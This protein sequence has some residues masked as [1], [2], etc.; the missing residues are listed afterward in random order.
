MSLIAVFFF[1]IDN[2]KVLNL[3]INLTTDFSLL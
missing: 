2:I 3:K 1:A